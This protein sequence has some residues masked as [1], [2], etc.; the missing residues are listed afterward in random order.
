MYVKE[1][2]ISDDQQAVADLN[3]VQLFFG[4]H[5]TGLANAAYML[6]G[7]AA[8]GA[9]LRLAGA[10]RE[11]RRLTV[12]HIGQLERLYRLLVLENVGDAEREETALFVELTSGSQVVHDI[13]RLAD[14]LDDLLCLF[15]QPDVVI[16]MPTTVQDAA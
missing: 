4:E 1:A 16:K 7:G 14:A 10:I 15:G 11:A 12:W 13:C 8:S 6:G 9:V 2:L 5:A 3:V